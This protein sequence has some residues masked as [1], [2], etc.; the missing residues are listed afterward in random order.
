VSKC[1]TCNGP[2][3]DHNCME[4]LTGRVRELESGIRVIAGKL[5]VNSSYINEDHV[6]DMNIDLTQELNKLWQL[7]NKDKDN[8]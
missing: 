5:S 8:G 7:S 2:S 3:E 1:I 6:R 4:Y